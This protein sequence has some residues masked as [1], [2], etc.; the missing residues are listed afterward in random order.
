MGK[1]LCVRFPSAIVC[2]FC[3]ATFMETKF[4]I[5]RAVPVCRSSQPP[6]RLS[7]LIMG[8]TFL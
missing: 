8:D 5:N 7:R 4:V 6:L 3:A 1:P 2:L